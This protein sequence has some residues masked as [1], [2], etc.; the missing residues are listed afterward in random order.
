MENNARVSRLSFDVTGL[1]D[2]LLGGDVHPAITNGHKLIIVETLLAA[3]NSIFGWILIGP[4][5]AYDTSP[6]RS[7]PVSLTASI[8]GLIKIFW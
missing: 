8:E 1:V 4:V 3:F 7:M 2:V 5:F 6:Y